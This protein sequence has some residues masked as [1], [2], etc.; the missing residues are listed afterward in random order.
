MSTRFDWDDLRIFLAVARGGSLSAAAKNLGATQPTVGRRVSTL[1]RKLASKLFLRRAQGLEL[2]LAGRSL[3]PH[4][5]RMEEASFGAERSSLVH[6][7]A[8]HG[9]IR[10][11]APEWFMTRSIAPKVAGFITRYPS[12]TI[13]LIAAS[14]WLNLPRQEAD[15]A[16]R[17]SKFEDPDVYQRSVCAVSFGLYAS[18]TYLQ[19][20]GYPDFSRRCEGHQMIELDF[21]RPPSADAAWIEAFVGHARVIAR[22]NGRQSQMALAVAGAGLVCLP[23]MMG[24]FAPSLQLLSPPEP[25]RRTLWIGMHRDMRAVP[26][27]EAFLSYF[28]E[29]LRRS[30]DPVNAIPALAAAHESEPPPAS[31][32]G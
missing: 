23:R 27:L 7:N 21:G 22:C 10:I 32:C 28:T 20:H 15:V 14:R 13:E 16:F 1:E 30:D 8:L 17:L 5:E 12:I 18:N 6:T 26:R 3:L 31:S 24:D 29:H 11:T 19:R 25:P 2:T 9:V 4:A